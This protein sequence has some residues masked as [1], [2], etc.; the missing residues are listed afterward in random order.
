[1]KSPAFHTHVG[2]RG[3]FDVAIARVG[4]D[5]K[6]DLRPVLTNRPNL[7]TNLGL[8]RL[9][10]MQIFLPFTWLQV[11]T[12]NAAPANGDTNLVSRVTTINTGSWEQSFSGPDVVFTRVFTFPTG[13]AAGN[14]AELGLSYTD[15]GTVSTRALFTDSEGDPVTVTVLADE[16]LVVTYRLIFSCATADSVWTGTV[17][18]TPY[19]LTLRPSS[20]GSGSIHPNDVNASHISVLAQGGWNDNVGE[21]YH[22]AASA[23]GATNSVPTGTSVVYGKG[24]VTQQTYTPGTYYRDCRITGGL[25]MFNH[26]NIGAFRMHGVPF[27]FQLGIS[28]RV[29]KVNTE[30]ITLDFRLS[31]GRA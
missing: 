4:S 28:P 2:A 3:E 16:Q 20:L 17:Q 31:W 13:A 26:T 10:T 27:F 25:S 23:I 6:T 15:T 24:A 8:D 29:T 9:G 18:G 5:G 12:G 22:G 7:I 21:L 19:T 14:L 30:V 11:G 1:M